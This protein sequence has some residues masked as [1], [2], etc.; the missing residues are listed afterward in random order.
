MIHIDYCTNFN[1]GAFRQSHYTNTVSIR[2]SALTSALT[3]PGDLRIEHG[4]TAMIAAIMEIKKNVFSCSTALYP[5]ERRS[6][7]SGADFLYCQD[8]FSIWQL[9][10]TSDWTGTWGNSEL[11]F[12]RMRCYHSGFK[13]AYLQINNEQIICSLWCVWHVAISVCL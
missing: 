6:Q 1:K 13:I 11:P 10:G 3:C 2:E 9:M 5:N 8:L 4:I 12:K 7:Q